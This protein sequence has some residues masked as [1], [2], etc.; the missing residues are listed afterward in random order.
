[1]KLVKG[2]QYRVP[3]CSL[4]THVQDRVDCFSIVT[5]VFASASA[6]CL[7]C[8]GRGNTFLKHDPV[9]RVCVSWGGAG[10]ADSWSLLACLLVALRMLGLCGWTIFGCASGPSDLKRCSYYTMVQ[11]N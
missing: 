9:H 6:V 3:A 4:P 1:M 2:S 10:T 11:W 8:C 7:A 5:F